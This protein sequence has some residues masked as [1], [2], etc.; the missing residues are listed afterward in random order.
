MLKKFDREVCLLF[1]ENPLFHIVTKTAFFIIFWTEFRCIVKVNCFSV[2]LTV[3]KGTAYLT[4]TA[5]DSG[6]PPKIAK[7]PVTVHFPDSLDAAGIT[8]SRSYV[9]LPHILVG[10]GAALLLLVCVVGLLIAYICKV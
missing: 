7:V 1:W 9:N 8:S 5:T 6:H 3:H 2:V 10:L 4:V